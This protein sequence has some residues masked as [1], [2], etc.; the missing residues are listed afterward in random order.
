MK[1]LLAIPV[2]LS[3]LVLGCDKA[4]FRSTGRER[5]LLPTG[6]VHR[7]WYFAGAAQVDIDGTINGDAFVAGGVINVRGTINGLLVVAGGEVNVTGTVTDRIVCVGAN[8]RMSGR[9]EKTMFAGGG[10]I[11]LERGSTVGEYLL[12]GGGLVD[13][14][15]T[16]G[17]DAKIAGSEVRLAG[18]VKGSVEASGD[19]VTTEEGSLV[20][21]DLT[22]ASKDS[23]AVQIA[24]G[25]VHGALDLVI[26]KEPPPHRALGYTTGQLMLRLLFV[27]SLLVTALVATL[28]C[29]R[30]FAA[31]GNTISARPGESI[32]AGLLVLFLVPLVAA[33]LLLTVIGIPLAVLIMFIYFWFAYL[34]QA[35]LG[36]FLGHRMAGVEGKRGWGLFG[37]AALGILVVHACA[38]IPFVNVLVYV[39]GLIVGVG[40]VVLIAYDEFRVVRALEPT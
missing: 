27:L 30:Q 10:T 37:P 19:R 15:G 13:V 26:G 3:L 32:L 28:L 7:G 22:V 20:D 38:L 35:A 16:V 2:L 12:A 25:T 34:S 29:P 24:P 36:I 39:G 21:G 11:L 17:R 5:V 1:R 31:V 23:S 33:V 18:E 40:A 8:I 9:T 6:E 14:R 4:H